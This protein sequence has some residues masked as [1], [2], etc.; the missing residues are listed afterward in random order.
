MAGTYEELQPAAE[1][2]DASGIKFLCVTLEKLIYLKRAARRPRT[3]EMLARLEAARQEIRSDVDRP[4][5]KHLPFKQES[6]TT[7]AK[8]KA[9][10]ASA[11][12]A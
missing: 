4:P 3:F 1:W 7:A 11:A 6:E 5:V 12:R 8:Q 10:A 2:R 9:R